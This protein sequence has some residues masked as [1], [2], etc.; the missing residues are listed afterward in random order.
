MFRSL[1]KHREVF[2][3]AGLVYHFV[4]R[5][6]RPL[7][8]DKQVLARVPGT[9]HRLRLRLGTSDLDVFEEIFLDRAL[10]CGLELNGELIIDGGAYVGFS[11]AY[12][13][14]RYPGSQIAAVELEANNYSQ[15][16]GNCAGFRNVVPIR[17]GIW[18]RDCKLSVV[19][20]GRKNWGY[21]ARETTG[22]AGGEAQSVDAL[23]VEAIMERFR[24]NEVGILKLDIEGAEQQVFARS[25]GWI[26]RVKC[27]IVE[28]HDDVNP[29]CSEAFSSAI[30]GIGGKLVPQGTKVLFVRG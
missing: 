19:D 12:F 11:T 5:I 9:Q 18:D 24:V 23:T 21:Q 7:A 29:G 25:A 10:E 13:A 1:K 16:L 4:S 26:R 3:A 27:L 8:L 14:L 15:L 28:L 20:P 2:G 17:A 22:P 30:D 6:A